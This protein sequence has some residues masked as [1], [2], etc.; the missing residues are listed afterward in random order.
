RVVLL[1]HLPKSTGAKTVLAAVCG[2]PLERIEMHGTSTAELYFLKLGDAGNFM[3]YGSGGMF[4]ING[5]N[6]QPS[7]QEKSIGIH[8]PVSMEIDHE[9]VVNGARRCLILKKLQTAPRSRSSLSASGNSR[10]HVTAS[11]STPNQNTKGT[12][13]SEFSVDEA[14]R[15]FSKYGT[16]V[17]IS[18]VI[19]RKLCFALHFADVRSAIAAKQEMELLDSSIGGKYKDWLVWYGKDPTDVPVYKV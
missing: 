15:D 7:W 10:Y 5:A 8:Q 19:S 1:S 9:M 14:L 12:L 11:H 18:P 13:I 2:G 3:E 4:V 16:I 17:D 6:V